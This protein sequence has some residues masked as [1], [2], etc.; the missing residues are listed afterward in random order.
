M[1]LVDVSRI[2]ALQNEAVRFLNSQGDNGP[3]WSGSVARI[4]VTPNLERV[5]LLHRS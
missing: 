4:M 1:G 3:G 5:L 2:K